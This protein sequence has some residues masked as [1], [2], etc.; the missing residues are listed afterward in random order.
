MNKILIYTQ[1]LDPQSI[2]S[3]VGDLEVTSV[4]SF[5]ELA[6]E[7]AEETN[8]LCVLIQIDG[9]D[10]ECRTF[11]NALKKAFPI[12]N[13]G[14]ITRDITADMPEGYCRIDVRLEGDQFNQEVQK[15][16]SSLAMS[17]RREYNRYDW[18]LKGYLSLD[19][20]ESWTEYALRS[21]SAGGA[22]LECSTG[23][24]DPGSKGVLRVVFQ[25]FK[26]LTQCEVIDAR[27]AS[28]HLPPG[29]GVRFNDLSDA[30]RDIIDHIVQDALRTSLLEPESE[31]GVPSLGAEDMELTPDFELD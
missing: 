13:V 22:F 24:P 4:E 29:F 27:H 21:I 15:C 8:L 5:L 1:N 20:G 23:F 16:I 12:L 6:E 19:D 10:E 11:L 9:L 28:S 7:V 14:V 3:A 30:S 2:I 31:V 18:S 25:D 17:N 26:L